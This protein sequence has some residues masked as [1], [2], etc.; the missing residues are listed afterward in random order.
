[1]WNR[2]HIEQHPGRFGEVSVEVGPDELPSKQAEID[3]A[4][5]DCLDHAALG[6]HSHGA[7]SAGTGRQLEQ[8]RRSVSNMKPQVG[9]GSHT[10]NPAHLR[11]RRPTDRPGTRLVSIKFAGWFLALR[12]A[13]RFPR[14]VGRVQGPE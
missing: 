9:G 12:H 1:M 14:G 2:Q 3:S 6:H 11:T 13:L 10:L 5:L 7:P 4:F 8:A